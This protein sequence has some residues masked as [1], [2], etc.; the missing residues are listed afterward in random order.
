MYKVTLGD[1]DKDAQT[2]GTAN[3]NLTQMTDGDKDDDDDNDE[4]EEEETE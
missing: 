1:D 3:D 2:E 4:D